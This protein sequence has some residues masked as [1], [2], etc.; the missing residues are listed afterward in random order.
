MEFGSPSAEETKDVSDFEGKEGAG[1]WA[2]ST[3][4]VSALNKDRL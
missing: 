3:Y 1:L 2:E 4:D